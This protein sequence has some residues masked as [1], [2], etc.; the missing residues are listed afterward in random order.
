[1]QVGYPLWV[2]CGAAIYVNPSSVSFITPFRFQALTRPGLQ[3]T[4]IQSSL[5]RLVIQLGTFI[6]FRNL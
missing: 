4:R 5:Q 1:M 2:Y 6:H 3:V